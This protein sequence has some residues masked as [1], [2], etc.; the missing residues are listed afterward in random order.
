MKVWVVFSS[1]QM[2]NDSLPTDLVR[3]FWLYTEASQVALLEAEQFPETKP[4]GEPDVLLLVGA[5]GPY[6]GWRFHVPGRPWICAASFCFADLWNLYTGSVRGEEVGIHCI[7]TNCAWYVERT[8]EALPTVFCHK[9]VS[10][11]ERPVKRPL[12]GTVLTNVEDRD[13]SLVAWVYERMK[14]K[15]AGDD[16]VIMRPARKTMCLPKQLA[17][18]HR[19]VY[20][21]D[22]DAYA[23]LK[24]FVPAPR[25]TDYRGGICPELIKAWAAGCIPLTI[26]HQVIQPLGLVPY[27]SLNGLEADLDRIISGE[28]LEAPPG[29]RD[30]L[31]PSPEQ[32]AR[33]VLGA[34]EKWKRDHVVG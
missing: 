14:E 2:G 34:R 24:Y 16:F 20:A 29:P 1:R 27:T 23:R 22:S 8:L 21:T 9:P 31:R 11:S 5:I 30:E 26:V 7:M 25:L 18:T 17:D 12:V 10:V 33:D 32:F 3:A 15:G 13:F 6:L 4:E 19:P 28:E